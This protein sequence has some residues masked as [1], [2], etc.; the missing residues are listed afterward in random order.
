AMLFR[1]QFGE[2]VKAAD[3]LADVAH[4]IVVPGNGLDELL[5]A[6][7]DNAG[8]GGVVERA[9]EYADDVAADDLVF[10]IAEAFVG[11]GLHGGV[12]FFGSNF[13][14]EDRDQFGQRAG[15]GGNALGAAIE[16]AFQFGQD[17][18]DSLCGAG[19]VGHDIDGCCAGAAEIAF[20]MGGVLGVL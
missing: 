20:G 6:V 11:S 1:D 9:I 19:A 2:V 18:A 17:Q 14:I 10:C 5:V 7:G 3:E 15:E 16:L 4:F 8:L 13:F 12:H